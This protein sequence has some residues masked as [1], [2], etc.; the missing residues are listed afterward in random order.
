ML[1]LKLCATTP[2][3]G[4]CLWW[5]GS[6]LS[7]VSVLV[8]CVYQ[9]L[10]VKVYITV[11]GSASC[12]GSIMPGSTIA[13]ASLENYIHQLDIFILIVFFSA[14]ILDRAFLYIRV[15]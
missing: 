7:Q 12:S 14:L 4:A 5:E 9:V 6:G 1:G 15:N 8:F 2:V 13:L 11:P 10:S 3:F